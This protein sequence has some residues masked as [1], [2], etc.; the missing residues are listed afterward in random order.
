[1]SLDFWLEVEVDTG[2]SELHRI[3]L[4]S[5]NITHNLRPMAEEV[6]IYKCLW[7]PYDLYENPTA[8]MLVP[9]LESGLLKLK[10][11]PK[12]YKQF[13]ASNGWGTYENFVIFVEGVLNAC[14]EHPKA[15]AKTSV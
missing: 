2:A 5:A 12:Y 4:Y 14:K 15:N 6:G 11:H 8:G 1:M 9:H 10:S 7:H 3:E 13:N